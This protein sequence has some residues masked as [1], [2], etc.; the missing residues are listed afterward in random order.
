MKIL[1]LGA[2]GCFGQN[3]ADYAMQEGHR[4]IGIGRSPKK[5]K[6]FSLGID[7]PYYPYHIAF[8]LDYILEKVRYF[9]PDVIVNYAAQGEGAASWGKD[10][11]RFYNTNV[12]ALV[13]L[14]TNIDCHFIQIGSSEVYGSVNAPVSEQALTNPT[15]PYSVSKLAFDQHLVAMHKIKGLPMNIIRPSNCIVEGQQLHRIVPKSLISGLTRRPIFLHG[16]GVARKSYLHATDLSRAVIKVIKD[17]SMGEI[18]NVGPEEPVTIRNLVGICL[19]ACN[20]S[21]HELVEMSAERTGQDSCY[22]LDSS[23]IKSLGWVRE[24]GLR[25][26]VEMVL[27]WI[28][29]YPELLEMDTSFVMRA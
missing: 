26:G 28:K 27:R 29:A 24:I 2:G 21:W 23:K 20:G 15:S 12:T 25:D 22:W 8:E 5:P 1:V 13:K 14:V 3:L 9:K 11:W 19:E 4:V 7:F 17:G 18:Y 10:N 16:G 6:C